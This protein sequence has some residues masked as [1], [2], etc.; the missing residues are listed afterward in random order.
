MSKLAN[1]G[2]LTLAAMSAALAVSASAGEGP[3]FAAKPT[4][5]SEAA[6][7]RIAFEA[8]A[9]TDVAVEVLDA[10]GA[11][12]RHLAAGVLGDNP[13]EPLAKGLKQSL[14]WDGKDDAGRQVS[15]VSVQVSGA[16]PDT[17]NLTPETKYQPPFKAR[18]RLGLRADFDRFIVD[19][20]E[21]KPAGPI[22]PMLA[23]GE[24]NGL[25]VDSQGNL[26]VLL[27]CGTAGI[28][29]RTENRLVVLSPEGK[30]LR[31]TVPF[32]ANVA[33]EKLAGV[34]FVSAEPGRLF[35]RIYERV[36]T[37]VLP[38]FESL[39]PQT[40][41]MTADDRLVLASGWATEL[42]GFGPRSLLVINADGSIP[43]ERFNGPVLVNGIASGIAHV[44]VSPDGKYAYV[45][46]LAEGRYYDPAKDTKSLHHT[47]LRVE[48]KVDAKPEVFFGKHKTA[49]AGAELLNDPRGLAVD[50]KGQV[51]VSDLVNDRVVVLSP[52]GKLL[53]EI[54]APAPATLVVHP[55]G[56]ALYLFTAPAA[57]N[58][59]VLKLGADGQQAWSHPLGASPRGRPMQYP[60]LAIDARGAQTVVYVGSNS[61]YNKYRLLKLVDRGAQF[62][63]SELLP[64][65]TGFGDYVVSVTPDD[66]VYVRQ[67]AGPSAANSFLETGATGERKPWWPKYYDRA[68]VGRD[69]LAYIYQ[70]DKPKKG[71]V[72]IERATLGRE[73]RP[74]GADDKLSDPAV[75]AFWAGRRANLFVPPGGEMF[76][77]E[78]GEQGGGK[79]SILR[80][81]SDGKLAGTPVTGLLGPIGVRVDRKGNI[82]T[83]DNLK[84][85]GVYWPKELDGFIAKL[86]KKGRDEYAE[87]YGAIL[88]FGP[89][90]G[91][92]KPGAAGA[93]ARAMEICAGEK[94]F[95]VEG[96]VDCHVGI[97]PLAPLRTGFKS[98]CWCL[99]ASFDLDA[100]DRL[101]VPD[102]ARFRV[103]VLD[104][105][106]N[107]ITSF[108][109]YDSID[110]PQGKAN[111]PGPEISFECPLSVHVSDLAAYVY[112]A[113]PC[114]RRTM[115]IKLTYAA[116]ETCALP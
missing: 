60:S 30:Y 23:A 31:T 101:F 76:Y 8:A 35:P 96:L 73:P 16:Q 41:A 26:H 29:G 59:A 3:A 10:K 40:M 47:V 78:Y 82:Y 97:S 91:S 39:P 77:L 33:R 105:N 18:V 12:V 13:P 11:V 61:E 15:G 70:L 110:A 14:A 112:D 36:C 92:V 83:A 48:L 46:G 19:P 1:P 115:R 6:G 99:G 103:Q 21:G 107:P 53:R 100:H 66:A 113:A 44:G 62:D 72:R 45:T 57:G 51:Y 116:E 109:G 64:A 90:G 28:A 20:K 80:Y 98:K 5:S 86:D 7:S 24:K 25:A 85:A 17:R 22:Q 42:Y 75:G 56:E 9:P 88:K 81:G 63:V 71:D 94:K 108:G 102:S 52:D 27:T 104:S 38:Q 69:G 32:R 89:K 106:L 114:A 74:F 34:D 65:S 2:L 87:T 54:K 55:K 67:V 37:T 49:G 84:P 93:G 58:A 68:I 50:G 4:V 43:R 111:Q 79:T 95:A